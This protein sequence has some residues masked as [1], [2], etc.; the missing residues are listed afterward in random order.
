MSSLTLPSGGVQSTLG[1]YHNRESIH[2]NEWR[3]MTKEVLNANC[4]LF[5][6]HKETG[7]E[8]GW[9]D[10]TTQKTDKTIYDETTSCTTSKWRSINAS[11]KHFSARSIYRSEIGL[12]KW[13]KQSCQTNPMQNSLRLIINHP[14][15]KIDKIDD[16]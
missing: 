10:R 14:K 16:C 15:Q 11:G 2:S 4:T 9:K 8:T 3:K 7:T 6:N 13:L 5:V 1:V 12:Q